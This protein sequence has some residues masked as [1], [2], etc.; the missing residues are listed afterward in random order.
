[1]RVDE[2][3]A[4]VW[5]DKLVFF[6]GNLQDL[7][8]GKISRKVFDKN[9]KD[10]VGFLFDHIR[11]LKPDS[12]T[13]V[14]LEEVHSLSDKD[15]LFKFQKF[16]DD[17]RDDFPELMFFKKRWLELKA[18]VTSVVSESRVDV[19]SVIN[20][21]IL[22]LW[23]SVTKVLFVKRPELR[24]KLDTV[25][26]PKID[27]FYSDVKKKPIDKAVK[28]ELLDRLSIFKNIVSEAKFIEEVVNGFLDS[29]FLFF[30]DY[31]DVDTQNRLWT[32]A[33]DF[34]MKKA[35]VAKARKSEKV[36]KE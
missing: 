24:K 15:L 12:K 11:F 13:L 5:L 19:S 31:I 10:A 35:E 18:S 36:F 6:W 22:G 9:V 30:R 21:V 32:A 2:R 20:T 23:R 8:L 4:D 33:F 28:K 17:L 14:F 16:L 1:M 25:L 26:I 27:K 7:I 29:L 34:L 3:K